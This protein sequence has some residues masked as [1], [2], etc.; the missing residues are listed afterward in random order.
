[1]VSVLM[2]TT[3]LCAQSN[4]EIAGVYLKKAERNYANL[5]IKESLKDFNKALKYLDTITRDNVAELGV[6]IHYEA[7]NYEEAKQYSKKYFQLAKNRS[8]ER[9]EEMLS[10]YVK[11]EEKLEQ[12]AEEERIEKEKREKEKRRLKKIDSLKNVWDGLYKTMIVKADSIYSFNKDSLAVYKKGDYYG[13]MNDQGEVL[14]NASKY[15][16]YKYF[17]GYILFMNSNVN[18]T[19][20]YCYN[21]SEKKGYRIP[22]ISEFSPASTNY[23]KVMLPRANGKLVMYPNN[24]NKVVVFDL[25]KEKF[26]RIANTKELLKNL[27]RSDVIDRFKKEDEVKIQ[28]EWYVFGGS[29]GGGV[30][31]IFNEDSNELYGYLFSESKKLVSKDKYPYL[32]AFYNKKLQVITQKTSFWINEQGNTIEAPKQEKYTGLSKVIKRNDGEYQFYKNIN[33]K[34][35]IILG[36]KKLKT[37]KDYLKDFKVDKDIFETEK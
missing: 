2:L 19:K 14:V 20:V 18:P 4:Y 30:Y 3:N 24:T 23:G 32:G 28:G 7:A 21:S 25:E 8:S 17:D 13:V 16:S 6:L 34:K 10:L 15:S 37:F 5:K 27:K 29:I 22:D 33:G 9:Y 36:D 31:P 35:Y 12:K 1:M 26:I 11:I